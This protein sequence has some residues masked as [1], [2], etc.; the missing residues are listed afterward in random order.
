[1][2]RVVNGKVNG[3]DARIGAGDDTIKKILDQVNQAFENE[4]QEV[5]LENHIEDNSPGTVYNVQASIDGIANDY[6]V[7]LYDD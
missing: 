2:L 4:K 6:T 3:K 7:M 5:L 1:M